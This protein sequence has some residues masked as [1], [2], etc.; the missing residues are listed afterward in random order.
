MPLNNCDIE[1]FLA[2]DF[3]QREGKRGRDKQR[4][5]KEAKPKK[6]PNHEVNSR[7]TEGKN[8]MAPPPRTDDGM[9]NYPRKPISFNRM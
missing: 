4:E 8:F 6:I 3:K 2:R 5:R 9:K 1:R 7:F